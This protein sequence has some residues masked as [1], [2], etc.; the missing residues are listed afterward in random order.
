MVIQIQ[1]KALTSL[2]F[3]DK[4]SEEE[5][6]RKAA[7]EPSSKKKEVGHSKPVELA[8]HPSC[9]SVCQVPTLLDAKR[10]NNTEI[11]LTGL[12]IKNSVLV[13]Q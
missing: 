10:T 12:G 13:R 4:K 5:S 8:P 3:V 2:F 11:A 7:S 9:L 1:I 6:R